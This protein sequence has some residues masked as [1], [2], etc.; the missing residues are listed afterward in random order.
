[1]TGKPQPDPGEWPRPLKR[2]WYDLLPA[3]LAQPN[4]GAKPPGYTVPDWLDHVAALDGSL[5]VAEKARVAAEESARTAEDKA[6]S[7]LQTCLALLTIT[8][9]L[10]TYQLTF[11]L[12]RDGAAYLT[13]VPIGFALISLALAAFE[14]SQVPRVAFY[15]RPEPSDLAGT[16]AATQLAAVLRAEDEGLRLAKW[17]SKA[18]FSDLMQA[19]AWFS[20]GLLALLLA[21]ILAAAC[22]ATTGATAE[23]STTTTTTSSSTT[24]SSP[25]TTSG[26]TTSTATTAPTTSATS[27]P[28]P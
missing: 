15:R 9:A 6:A 24:T 13:L 10:G 11:A 18:K 12:D 5:A 1:M 14:A 22:R 28:G 2:V 27:T 3:Q 21:G 4:D 23:P 25:T 7:L 20:R 26:G 19:R 8:V 17:A 16:T